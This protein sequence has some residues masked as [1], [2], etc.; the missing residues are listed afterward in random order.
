[1][2]DRKARGRR[3]AVRGA[4][5][6]GLVLLGATAIGS[7][8]KH[9]VY[10]A[11]AIAIGSPPAGYEE[12]FWRLADGVVLHGWHG[13]AAARG[14]PLVLF[15]HGNGENLQTLEWSGLFER[16]RELDVYAVAVEYPGYGKSGGSPS[17]GGLVA[18]GLAA[19]DWAAGRFPDRP[20]V[21]AGWSLGAAVALQ[22][23]A[24]RPDR[25]AGLVAM[26]AWTRL[27]DVASAHFPTL[28]VRLLVREEY[29]SI[30]AAERVRCPSLVVH[31]GRDSIIPID[32]GRRIAEAL[33]RQARW[34]EIDGA[35][36]NDLLGHERVWR[37]LAPFLSGLQPRDK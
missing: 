6:L 35:G 27:A 5:A 13:G 36:H 8:V 31:G 1:M 18:G 24:A 20:L 32:H 16:W 10:P 21:V 3:W 34:L 2:D 29:D 12:V 33:G 19:F 14:R 4:V 28:L 7:F 11:P 30:A 37:E 26:S 25:S 9:V 22:V 17:E 15:F 23:A